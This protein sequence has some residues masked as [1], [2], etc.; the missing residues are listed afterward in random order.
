MKTKMMA[1][2]CGFAAVW[3]AASVSASETPSPEEMWRIIQ[4]QQSQIEELKAQLATTTAQVEE[5][6]QKVEVA[7]DMIEEA[8][9]ASTSVAASWAER[10]RIGGYGEMHYNNWD[11]K[12]EIDFHRFVLYFNHD[13]TDNIKFV[14]EVEL[15][16]AIA[17]DGQNGEIELELS[18]IHI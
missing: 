4:A 16:H 6:D 13:F 10:T 5:T 18:L 3:L 8:G 7:G 1:A 15:E 17:G 9:Y 12:E 11:S 14:S 2:A